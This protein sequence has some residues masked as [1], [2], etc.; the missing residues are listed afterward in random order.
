M[1]VVKTEK[2]TLRHILSVRCPMCHAKPEEQCTL[3]TG[4][5][6][7]KTH[8]ART[9]AAAQAPPPGSLSRA[10]VRVA[11][12]VTSSSFRALFHHK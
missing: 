5:P 8:L 6:C 2:L 1:V 11:K 4:H 7:T 10:A 12:E 9:L 3:T